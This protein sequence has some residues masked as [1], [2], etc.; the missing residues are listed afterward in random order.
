MNRAV[1]LLTAFMN[2]VEKEEKGVKMRYN[3]EKQPY[4][5]VEASLYQMKQ[6]V[7]TDSL[8]EFS[9]EQI[10]E[11]ISFSFEYVKIITNKK[12]KRSGKY[13]VIWTFDLKLWS[14]DAKKNSQAFTE[15]W[16][17]E[18]E[19]SSNSSQISASTYQ[20]ASQ[21]QMDALFFYNPNDSDIG[22]CLNLILDQLKIE[23]LKVDIATKNQ[24]YG[25]PYE[26]W[27]KRSIAQTNSVI[28]CFSDNWEFWNDTKIDSFLKKFY[29]SAKYNN[30]QHLI[31]AYFS[32]NGLNFNNQKPPIYFRNDPLPVNLTTALANKFSSEIIYDLIKAITGDDQ[33][34][35]QRLLTL[36][37][38]KNKEEIDDN[39]PQVVVPAYFMTKTE[40]KQ[41]LKIDNFPIKA[42]ETKQAAMNNIAKK[43]DNSTCLVIVEN[44]GVA[45][46][47]ILSLFEHY[48]L[49]LPKPA[50][51]IETI[52]YQDRGEGTI[53]ILGFSNLKIL[54]WIRDKKL[55][56]KCF[57]IDFYRANNRSEYEPFYFEISSRY[58][59]IDLAQK[60]VVTYRE[61]QDK[62]HE[63]ALIAKCE[64]NNRKI[65]LLAGLAEDAT[66]KL[67]WYF[68][69]HWEYIYEELQNKKRI[70]LSSDDTFAVVIRISNNEVSDDK[71]SKEDFDIDKICIEQY[72][73]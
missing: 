42:I 19:K 10:R 54:T 34:K 49:P 40:I 3:T 61:G 32:G 12:V 73:K 37:G 26:T 14:V 27:E 18:K 6:W 21:S 23:G 7:M 62:N 51:D 53:I 46:Y 24:R 44:D 39:I 13:P 33:S 68:R 20:R 65:I 45:S 1:R 56:G 60:E 58:T 41:H 30:L 16:K 2:C 50:D 22:E 48:N 69:H 71:L 4:L 11:T 55:K 59:N 72:E 31:P 36:T 52:I 63:Y 8:G 17:V 35:Q 66:R 67:G 28:V 25:E 15:N 47:Y 5:S 29:K 38:Y 57:N 70:R 43:R 64:L 9:E